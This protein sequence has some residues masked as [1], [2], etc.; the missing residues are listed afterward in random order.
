MSSVLTTFRY[1]A[2]QTIST[3]IVVASLQ[4]VQSESLNYGE[5][6]V[7]NPAHMA[8][9]RVIPRAR[10]AASIS[11]C[12][13]VKWVFRFE[14]FKQSLKLIWA[15]LKSPLP[16]ESESDMNNETDIT[17]LSRQQYINSSVLT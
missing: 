7:K 6:L 4:L 10:N 12:W 15:F 5:T 8:L 16:P 11:L 1:R 13:H 9:E 17:Q 3:L 2:F 14:L